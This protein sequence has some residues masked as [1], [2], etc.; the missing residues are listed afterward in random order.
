MVLLLALTTPEGIADLLSESM[1]S[2]VPKF[3]PFYEGNCTKPNFAYL[4]SLID[5]YPIFQKD[6]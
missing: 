4:K 6:N 5:K 2:I 1:V 3:V